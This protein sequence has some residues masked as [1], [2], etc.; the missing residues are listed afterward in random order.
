MDK[1]IRGIQH[2]QQHVFPTNQTLFKELASGQ[3]PEVLMVGCSDSR[4]ALDLIT[5]CAPGDMFVCRNAGNIVPPHADTDA[6]SATIE[7]A[8]SALNVQHIVICGHSDCGAMKGLLHPEKVSDMP[9]VR[10]WI[11]HADGARRAL[12]E[13]NPGA[14]EEQALV[15]VTKLNV[16]LQLEHLR[17]HPHVFAQTRTRNLKLHGWVFDIAS[18]AIETWDEEKGVWGTLTTNCSTSTPHLREMVP[19]LT[20]K[21]RPIHAFSVA[22]D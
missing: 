7:F 3:N 8:V 20:L 1:L 21:S 22:G 9:Q 14:T 10:R 4:L 6:V 2:F 16:R 11:R 13:L 5:Q 19:N 17:T 15:A 12:D 18:G